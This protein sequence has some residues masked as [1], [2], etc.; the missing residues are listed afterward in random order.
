M[1]VAIELPYETLQSLEPVGG[2]VGVV[3]SRLRDV[4]ADGYRRAHFGL[5][6]A[7][8]IPPSKCAAERQDCEQPKTY[9]NDQS[10][11][12]AHASV[13]LCKSILTRLRSRKGLWR[14][15]VAAATIRFRPRPWPWIAR[16][17]LSVGW[18]PSHRARRFDRLVPG[19]LGTRYLRS[20]ETAQHLY[21][22]QP[23]QHVTRSQLPA[24][25]VG[26]ANNAPPA[27]A[28]SE[29]REK[30]PLEQV[31]AAVWRRG[32]SLGGPQSYVLWPG[33][34]PAGS[35][36]PL[37]PVRRSDRPRQGVGIE[38][39][40][41]P[42]EAWWHKGNVNGRQRKGRRIAVKPYSRTS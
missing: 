5:H 34:Y 17:E 28:A 7:C 22:R 33:Q 35:K 39:G 9:R 38:P 23:L 31:V 36:A 30:I 41:V 1:P 27:P 20:T 32:L 21:H 26:A 4:L 40:I 3:D 25:H 29:R 15:N 37:S 19:R 13:P 6:L 11:P 2:L 8:C 42:A 16:F 24:A 10:K 14:W 12:E 18:P